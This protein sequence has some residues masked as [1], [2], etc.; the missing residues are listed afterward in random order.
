M[1]GRGPLEVPADMLCRAAGVGVEGLAGRRFVSSTA[2]RPTP[3]TVVV[4]LDDD[5]RHAYGA[6]DAGE[7]RTRGLRRPHVAR[8]RQAELLEFYR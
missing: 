6:Y 8:R 2:A 4:T 3:E 7:P 1:D 5:L